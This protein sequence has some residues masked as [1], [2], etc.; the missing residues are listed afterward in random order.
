MFGIWIFF[1]DDI[2]ENNQT[3]DENDNSDVGQDSPSFSEES[4]QQ[5]QLLPAKSQITT[6]E[7]NDSSFNAVWLHLIKY[8]LKKISYLLELD[9]LQAIPFLQVSFNSLLVNL[10]FFFP[11]IHFKRKH[12]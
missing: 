5:Q 4:A 10:I 7:Q 9:G 6:S 2:P 3:G 11:F 8:F 12:Y 1:S